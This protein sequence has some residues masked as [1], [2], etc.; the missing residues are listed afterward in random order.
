MLKFFTP[1][2]LEL[3]TKGCSGFFILFD[4]P[5]FFEC[6]EPGLF[7][8]ANNSRSKQN[9]TNLKDPFEHIGR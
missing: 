5:G 1:F 3:S 4:K 7:I 6:V 2:L 8:L 9:E